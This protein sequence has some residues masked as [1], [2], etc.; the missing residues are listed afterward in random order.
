MQLPVKIAHVQ[1]VVMNA[2]NF[3]E[4]T[5]GSGDE[6]MHEQGQLWR[7]DLRDNEK[8]V[9]VP[10]LLYILSGSCMLITLWSRLQYCPISL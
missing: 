4:G 1:E 7:Q 6:S 2:S 5:L 3:Y 8:G 9:M 10:I